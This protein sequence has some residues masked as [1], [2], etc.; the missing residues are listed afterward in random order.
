MYDTLSQ[1]AERLRSSHAVYRYDDYLVIHP[2]GLPPS[3][4]ESNVSAELQSD[5]LMQAAHIY[6][7]RKPIDDAEVLAVYFK[8]HGRACPA[9]TIHSGM[10]LW[11]DTDTLN[12]HRAF[13]IY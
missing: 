2:R 3:M 10:I 9:P 12:L 7:Q 11:L 8:R 6:Q 13:H 1:F 4:T 5:A